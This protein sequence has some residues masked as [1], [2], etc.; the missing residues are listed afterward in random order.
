MDISAPTDLLATSENVED[1]SELLSYDET[2]PYEEQLPT[3]AEATALASRIGNTKVY[4]LSDSSAPTMRGGKRKRDGQEEENADDLE[5]DIEMEGDPTLRGNALLLTGAPVSNLPT[6]RLFAYATHFDSHPMGLEWI[7]DNTCI[8]VFKSKAAARTGLR[9]L[10]KLF[11]EE[12]DPDGYITAKPIPIAFWPPEQRINNSLRSGEDAQSQPTMKSVIK[13]RWAKVDDVKKRGARSDSEFYRKHGRMAGKELFNGRELPMK[14]R[15]RNEDDVQSTALRKEQLDEEL[16]EF[17]AEGEAED[18]A[19]LNPPSPP[20]KMRSDY[21]ADD[22]RTALDE[23]LPPKLDLASRIMAPLPRRGRKR[24]VGGGGGDTGGNDG[25]EKRLWSDKVDLSDRIG[26]ERAS[27]QNSGRQ[28]RNGRRTGGNRDRPKKTQQ[29][30][31]DE[32]D[33]FLRED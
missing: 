22:G 11:G 20:S 18:S 21:I 2:V 14:K 26:S 29:E 30:L 31:D 9:H 17:L 24:Q 25:L 6:A 12:P 3:G 23:S 5:E 27:S 16:N 13:M 33:A 10:S 32:L 15:R 7:D 28:E 4:L 8:L 1:T 19:A